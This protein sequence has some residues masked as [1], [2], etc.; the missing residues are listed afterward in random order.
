MRLSIPAGVVLLLAPVPALASICHAFVEG[1]PGVR[2][3]SLETPA[4]YAATSPEV[5]IRFVGHASWR[6]ESAGGVI[7]VT[8]YT[9]NAGAG[10]V[11]TVV[12]MNNAH[13]THYTDYPNPEIAHVLRGWNPT[14]DGPAE[15]ELIV[16][17]MVIRNVATDTRSYN[18][19]REHGNSI[20]VFEVAD[21]CIGHLGHLHHPLTDLHYAMLGRLDVLMV[22]VDGSYTMNTGQMIDVVKTLK[23]QIVLPMHWF[24]G[25]SL[26]RFI[27]GMQDSL[28]VREHETAELRVSRDTL[29]AEPTVVVMQPVWNRP[30]D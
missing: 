6:I 15:H 3:A 28:P 20:F 13:E 27:A 12:T 19:Y 7:A 24:G 29:P 10:P 9:G 8:D 17:D 2:Y 4:R 1:V 21:L 14:G 16:D 11:P 22:P 25:S 26:Q 18:G 23:S 30:L 5:S